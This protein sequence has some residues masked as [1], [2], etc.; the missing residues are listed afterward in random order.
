[1]N[2]NSKGIWSGFKDILDKNA[3]TLATFGSIA[4]VALTIYFMHKASKNAAKVEDKYQEDLSHVKGDILAQNSDPISDEDLEKEI[5]AETAR[6]KMNKTMQLIYVYRWA[7]LSGIGSAGFAILSNYL[8]GR[9][10]AALGTV[11]A[12]NTDKIKMGAEKIKDAIG[13]ERFNKIKEEIDSTLLDKKVMSEGANAETARIINPGMLEPEEG[14]ELFYLG[15]PF[16]DVAYIPLSQVRD[17]LNEA[18]KMSQLTYNDLMGLLGLETKDLGR[19]YYWSA[20]Q[21]NPFKAHIGYVNMGENGMRSIV[22]DNLPC[23]D[24]AQLIKVNQSRR[25][26]K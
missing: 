11:L 10:I 25:N 14:Y 12:M 17:A 3:P 5:K 22:F 19:Y 1:M 6:I 8:N 24:H 16:K 26:C 23:L 18:D 13:E 20:A 9:T 21:K 4:G 2:I 15:Y 7:L